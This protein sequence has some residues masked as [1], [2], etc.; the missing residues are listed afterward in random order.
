[1]TP[2]LKE[3]VMIVNL[4]IS[5]WGARKYDKSA[6]KEVEEAHQAR[7]AGRF[8]KVLLTSETL[9]KI[10]KIGT[11]LRQ[12][13]YDN[14][15]P[16]GDNGDRILPTEK[17]FTYVTETG[18]MKLEF[19]ELSDQFVNEYSIA[20][21]DAKRRLNS[22]Y[23]ESDY[24]QP[25]SIRKKFDIGVSFMPIAEGNDLRVNLS[26]EVIEGIKSQITKELEKRVNGA[27]EDILQRLR[28]AVGKM[29]ET[30]Q[31]KNKTFRDSLIGNVQ[32]LVETLPLLNF[33]NDQRVIDAISY[34]QNL[35]VDPD[36]LRRKRK[37]RFEIADKAKLI[38]TYI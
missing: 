18:N 19:N 29:A 36:E 16:W 6:T 12:Y 9:T 15:L 3:K 20:K 31:D 35:I 2:T 4:K 37:F 5:Q 10:G 11:R 30:L 34:C 27:T 14:T 24:P 22:L 13:H 8:N 33:N 17:F 28:D 7:E 38:L 26:A 23:K 32:S 25:E 21:E 1:M